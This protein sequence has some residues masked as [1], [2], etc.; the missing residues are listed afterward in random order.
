MILRA[1]PDA[2][3]MASTFVLSNY[4]GGGFFELRIHRV[5]DHFSYWVVEGDGLAN[6]LLCAPVIVQGWD[7][8]DLDELGLEVLRLIRTDDGLE[9]RDVELRGSYERMTGRELPA[10]LDRPAELA[11]AFGG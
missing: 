2:N 11:L 6:S 10:K 7:I 5:D 3:G 1:R 8:T 9:K 4:S